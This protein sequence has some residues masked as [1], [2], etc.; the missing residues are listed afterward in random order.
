MSG[1]P[2]PP[3]QY[4][5]RSEAAFRQELDRRDAQTL[6]RGQDIEIGAGRL[7]L[8]DRDTGARSLIT[9]ESGVLVATPL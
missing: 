3:A 2:Q 8:T 5:A 9:L 7:I 4:D 1:L 6:K